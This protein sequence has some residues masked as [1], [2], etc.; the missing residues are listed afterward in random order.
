[1]RPSP[2]KIER[3]YAKYEFS[4][5]YLISGSDCESLT[6][7]ELLA[8][9]PDATEKFHHQYLGYT[10]SPGAPTLRA[11]IARLYR[12]TT[13]EQI[14]VHTGAVE[15]IATF[16]QAVLEPGDTVIV[17][18]PHYQALSEIARSIGADVVP[19]LAREE[20]GWAPDLDELPNLITAKTRAVIVNLPHN[21]T[22]YLMTAAEQARLVEICRA[23]GLL[24]F[25]DEV[26]RE[27]EHDPHDTLPAACDLYENAVSL[28]VM[29]K[30]YGLPG[31][32]IGWIATRNSAVLDRVAML[33]DY[34]TICNAAPSEFLAALALR[35]RAGIVMRNRGIVLGN[36]KVLDGFFARYGHLFSWVRP[37]AGSIAFP[38]LK[39]DM[40][41]ERFAL[42]AIERAGVTLLPST[43]YNYGNAHFRIGFGRKS[44]P[45]FLPHFERYLDEHHGGAKAA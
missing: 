4:A 14:L 41:V 17:Q 13:P 44:L 19:W 1:M 10:E 18:T 35:H 2:F 12:G 36:M 21:P 30:T 34:T 24:L 28:G 33:K 37:H 7:G 38:R 23:R 42:D 11:E 20:Q 40:D 15:P 16:M 5:P 3:Y 45:S 26:Y 27:L 8:L 29:S 25:S 32:R 43:T 39:L 6:I 22:G 31:L 9:E